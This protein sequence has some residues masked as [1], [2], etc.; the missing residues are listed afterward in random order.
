MRKLD[1][2]TRA[3]LLVLHQA[4]PKR[5]IDEP[6]YPKPDLT[7]LR[8]MVVDLLLQTMTSKPVQSLMDDPDKAEWV[9]RGMDFHNDGGC[10]FCEKQIP[11]RRKLD[12]ESHFNA[13]YK[14]S[15]ASLER[16]AGYIRSVR[17]SFLS[18][19]NA[20][21]CEIIHDSL[22][23]GYM[24]A[25]VGL[26]GYRDRVKAYLDS[27]EAALSRKKRH[28]F[29]SLSLDGVP[30]P[31]DDCPPD[32]LIKI[33]REHNEMCSNLPSRA[34]DARERLEYDYVAADHEFAQLHDD[35][36]AADRAEV[37]SA[38]LVDALADEVSEM[39]R[40]MANHSRA[41]YDF[42]EDLRSYLGHGELRLDVREHGYAISRNG[43]ANPLP[44]DGERTAIALLYFLQSLRAGRFNTKE[45]IIVLD[46]PVSSLDANA[47]FAA[48]GFIRE[49]T[50]TA[51][52][53]FVLTHNFTFFREVREWFK[54]KKD[55]AQFY[56]LSS[57]SEG[58]S[59][60][61]EIR[62]L[63]P[64]LKNYGSDYH[65]L[66][67][68]VWNGARSG[69]LGSYYHLP[70]M[71]RRLLDSFLAFRQPNIPDLRG[72]MDKIE[73]D[74]AKKRR[75]YAF[76]NA[77]SHN[78]AIAGPEHAVDILSEAPGV[79]SDIMDLMRAADPKHYDA[80]KSLARKA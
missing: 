52:Q 73:Y 2:Q 15:L 75:I 50:Q 8:D 53:L 7:A 13:E 80:M 25:K 6:V 40:D 56:M 69:S 16:L 54:R 21:D 63:D 23:D 29:E 33:I 30:P 5:K 46:D 1:E 59:R 41:A 48:V 14:D 57:R 49:R 47:L 55:S 38:N 35:S 68:C 10:P 42:N 39:E 62:K 65:Y 71:A 66:F 72:R 9:R 77:H 19:L 18:D 67:K 20:P 79:L 3:G 45:G 11:Q 12:L 22:H 64:L 43:D 74:A 26:D 60:Q 32:D 70:N 28:L 78:F 37:D 31:P 27:L 34:A 61:S 36:L 24:A 58:K 17:E 76:I 51:G 44:S 4:A